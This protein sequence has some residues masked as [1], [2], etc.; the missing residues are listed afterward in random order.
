MVR[1][2]DASVAEMKRRDDETRAEAYQ[3]LFREAELKEKTRTARTYRIGFAVILVLAVA[4]IIIAVIARSDRR[5]AEIALVSMKEAQQAAEAARAEEQKALKTVQTATDEKDRALDGAL[6]LLST[7]QNKLAA[8]RDSTVDSKSR[9]ALVQ[10]EGVIGKQAED[11]GKLTARVYVHMSED[12]QRPAVDALANR[13]RKIRLGTNL[14]SVPSTEIQKSKATAL[15]CFRASECEEGK[16]LLE[17]L[18]QQ[19]QSPKLDLQDFS[20]RYEKSTGIRP[21]HYEVWFAPG[22]IRLTP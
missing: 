3:A 1:L 11:I 10:A 14:L 15:R 5:K 16:Q 22:E 21:R 19:L 7:A 8:A 18:N 4:A 6:A 13:M 17:L 12:A 9:E 20:A 2:I